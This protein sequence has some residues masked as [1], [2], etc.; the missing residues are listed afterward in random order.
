MDKSPYQ[1]AQFNSLED[2]RSALSGRRERLAENL[3]LH[4]H[5]H[6]GVSRHKSAGSGP[7]PGPGRNYGPSPP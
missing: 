7:G 2:R 5:P 4:L 6:R 3:T 1:A